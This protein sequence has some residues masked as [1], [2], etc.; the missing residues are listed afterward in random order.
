MLEWLRAIRK[1]KNL[2]QTEVARAAKIS[3]PSYHNIEYGNRRPSVE[4]A[5]RI[6]ECLDF[7]WTKFFQS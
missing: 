1:E 3:Q 6:A 7:E 2:R 4:T 5:K